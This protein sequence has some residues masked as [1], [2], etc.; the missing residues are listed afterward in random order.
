M[1]HHEKWALLASGVTTRPNGDVVVPTSN[2]PPDGPYDEWHPTHIDP[3]EVRSHVNTRLKG[4][5]KP[6]ANAEALLGLSTALL[7]SSPQS[8][9]ELL[10]YDSWDR[11]E[12]WRRGVV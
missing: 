4:V 7:R 3:E 5:V 8:L 11:G 10:S 6:L 2:V 12:H 9:Q 1:C